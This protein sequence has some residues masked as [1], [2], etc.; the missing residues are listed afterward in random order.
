MDELI[1]KQRR[2]QEVKSKFKRIG[3]R[4]NELK[5]MKAA[6]K[7]NVHGDALSKESTRNLLR[8]VMRVFLHFGFPQNA[9]RTV[10][11]FLPLYAWEDDIDAFAE[12]M[13]LTVEFSDDG[14]KKFKPIRCQ[15][16]QRTEMLGPSSMGKW[17]NVDGTL[18]LS[19]YEITI[20]GVPFTSEE[21]FVPNRICNFHSKYSRRLRRPYKVPKIGNDGPIKYYIDVCE[22][23]LIKVFTS[24]FCKTL[25]EKMEQTVN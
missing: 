11:S 7:M 15:Q 22:R 6:R 24:P 13:Y 1:E 23:E 17:H 4:Q 12:T 18:T 25:P 20:D 3:I 5:L 2:E 9:I 16:L 19:R 21:G 10:A 8:Q 14:Y